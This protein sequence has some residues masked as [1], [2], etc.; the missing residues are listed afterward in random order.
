[1]KTINNIMISIGEPNN[2]TLF[3]SLFNNFL[4]MLNKNLEREDLR[5]L[6]VVLKH[7]W[8]MTKTLNENNSEGQRNYMT[9]DMF[10]TLG[11]VLN[12]VLTL[13]SSAKKETADFIKKSNSAADMD[14]EDI[15]EL[16]D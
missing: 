3:M 4:S 5:E 1:M 14:E 2:V 6:K 9:G 13:V 16:K 8:L 12:K 15:E 10:N 11:P 7:F